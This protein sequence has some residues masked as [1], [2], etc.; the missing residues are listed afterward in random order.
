MRFIILTMAS[1]A[2]DGWFHIPL[3]DKFFAD[4]ALGGSSGRFPVEVGDLVERAEVVF[5]GTMAFETPSH[6]VR[7]G[8]VNDF[9]MVHMSVTGDAADAAI[10]VNGMVKVN[11]IGRFM[12]SHPRNGVA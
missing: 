4:L 10:H 1:A 11:V 6:A 5:G 3:F 12:N 7:F 8:V 2:A 9:H